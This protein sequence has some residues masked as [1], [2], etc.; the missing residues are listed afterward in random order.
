VIALKRG[1]HFRQRVA[2]AAGANRWHL[3]V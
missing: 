3:F 1:G 2:P